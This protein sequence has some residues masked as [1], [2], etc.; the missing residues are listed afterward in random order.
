[1]KSYL[2]SFW[3]KKGWN[4]RLVLKQKRDREEFLSLSDS[5]SAF[6]LSLFSSLLHRL[7]N[8]NEEKPNIVCQRSSSFSFFFFLSFDFASKLTRR[9]SSGC[10]D[11]NCYDSL[12]I[13]FETDRNLDCHNHLWMN[14]KNKYK[15]ME[16]I[17]RVDCELF[18]V[19]LT[20]LLLSMF[21]AFIEHDRKRLLKHLSVYLSVWF[22]INF[23]IHANL[24]EASEWNLN[25][26]KIFKK[27]EFPM[28]Y[29]LLNVYVWKARDQ[30][31]EFYE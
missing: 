5:L 30:W 23:V 10:V 31:E 8:R 22:I 14:K 18:D 20:L 9:I 6:F 21:S 25:L 4:K 28:S 2:Y 17:V 29:R 1:M 11:D 13:L 12:L 27:K 24:W 3:K 19:V 15:N 7:T 26:L 16:N